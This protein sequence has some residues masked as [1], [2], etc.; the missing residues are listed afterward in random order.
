MSKHL[1]NI[2]DHVLVVISVDHY[3]AGIILESKI[4]PNGTIPVYSVR[5]DQLDFSYT[6]DFPQG[7]LCIDESYYRDKRL[8]ELGIYEV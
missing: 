5:I 2:G 7:M 6:N 1:Y 3:Y 4:N 8:E